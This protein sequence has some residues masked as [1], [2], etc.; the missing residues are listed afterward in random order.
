MTDLTAKTLAELQAMTKAQITA[1]ILEGQMDT[2]IEES[3]DDPHGQ[4]S[5]AYVI[6]DRATGAVLKRVRTDWTYH[7][8]GDVADITTVE[9]D[10]DGKQ[11]ARRVVKHHRDGRMEAG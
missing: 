9:R 4:I 11:V 10:S 1:S 7:P 3:K 8:H 2:T 6:T 5:R